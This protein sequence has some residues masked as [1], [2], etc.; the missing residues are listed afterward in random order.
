MSELRIETLRMPAA[1]L[2]CDS[3]LPPLREPGKVIDGRE[4]MAE[5][6]EREKAKP[7]P[8]APEH[9]YGGLGLSSGLLPY[10]VQD[11]YGR[12]R[13]PRDFR[14]AVL[15]NETLRATFLLELG[16]RLWSL[17]HKPSGRELIGPNSV[18]QPGNLAI[19]GAWFS[20]GVEWNCGTIGHTP[21][22]C[23]PLFAARLRGNDGQ[24]ILRLYEWERVRQVVD[25]IDC[26]LPDGSEFLFVRVRLTNTNPDDLEMYW[27]SNIAVE[28]KAGHRVVVP[29]CDA[30]S[31]SYAGRTDTVPVP[32]L[33]G[34]DVSYPTNVPSCADFFYNIPRDQRPWIASLDPDGRGLV[35]P[36][37]GRLYGRKLFVWGQRRGGLR[38]QD[39]LS[40]G[41]TPYIE[42]QAGL[43]PT[44]NDT[45][46]M[47]AGAD[48]SWIEAYGLMQA[49]PAVM[50]GEDWAAATQDVNERLERVLPIDEMGR[51]L[52]QTAASA[53]RA[54]DEIIQRGSGWGALEDRQR[55]AAGLKLCHPKSLVF[56][57]DSLT[58]KQAPWLSLLDNG[59]M[60]EPDP[61]D[62]PSSFMVQPEWRALLEQAV[63]DKCR[64]NWFAW[65]QLGIMRYA[66]DDPNA[67]GQ[68]WEK[69]IKL[70]RSAW[71]LR[72][73]A[74]KAYHENRSGDAAGLWLEAAR[75]AP[76]DAR[77]A[78][79]CAAAMLRA[80][81]YADLM[82][83]WPS[84]AQ[85]DLT[86]TR[87][88]VLVAIAQVELGQLDEVE[89]FL[90]EPKEL[91][92]IR[93]GELTLSN[94]WF[95][96]QENRLAAGAGTGVTDAV[97]E[98]VRGEFPVPAHLDFRA[99]G[100]D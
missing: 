16:A 76:G 34:T 44:Q 20:G 13:L 88:R 74:V 56:D 69:S 71:A 2:G 89:R 55:Q 41:G 47:P 26:S 82:E 8:A 60:P 23:S 94:L 84:L 9:R 100:A 61:A 93:E 36:S 27:W 95:A 72:N 86:A 15:E 97:R 81:R 7:D 33:K 98:R 58:E 78:L 85:N 68:A 6:A 63:K 38:W 17:I 1:S 46:T 31:W 54:P 77:L 39:F 19:R 57:D 83:L 4:D 53:D 22:T 50:H 45:I 96:L 51:L 65:L 35:H 24:P 79:E 11:G 49:D 21:Y 42:I 14:V 80:R 70:K 48:W 40:G 62:P 64:D 37:T 59:T 66:G 52:E 87:M 99:G 92:D 30:T 90:L 25:Q 5:T 10:T 18:F 91:M 75:Q 3:P 12:E 43:A 67:A 73:L 29:A 32:Y 28:E